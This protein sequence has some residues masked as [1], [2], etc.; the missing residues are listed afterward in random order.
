MDTMRPMSGACLCFD[1]SSD[2]ASVDAASMSNHISAPLQAR[3]NSTAVKSL[4]PVANASVNSSMSTIA[5]GVLQ[6]FNA[7]QGSPRL[8]FELSGANAAIE[9]ACNK[10]GYSDIMKFLP[11]HVDWSASYE[12]PIELEMLYVGD[13]ERSVARHFQGR[14]DTPYCSKMAQS[15]GEFKDLCIAN[16][17]YI[18]NSCN[19]A[20]NDHY[21]WK[22]GGARTSDCWRWSIRRGLFTTLPV[23]YM[24]NDAVGAD[25]Y[26]GVPEYQDYRPDS[27]CT[28][29]QQCPVCP[30][31]GAQR[32]CRGDESDG[33]SYC[34]CKP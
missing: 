21:W 18:V 34:L 14:R 20:R 30:L 13:R 22:S 32:K 31:N 6:C 23:G 19:T 24:H 33:P 3:S 4:A 1:P 28:A 11:F 15:G 5:S 29:W 27:W 16:M 9:Y 8:N 25:D 26:T 7:A 2:S 10:W 12:D 17:Q